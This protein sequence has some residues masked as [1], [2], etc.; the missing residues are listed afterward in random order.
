VNQKKIGF[1]KQ[2]NWNLTS[3]DHKHQ[4][5]L[6]IEATKNADSI[7]NLTTKMR[8]QHWDSNKINTTGNTTKRCNDATDQNS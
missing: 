8:L 5:R 6:R 3:K 2:K 4:L 1:H 7:A